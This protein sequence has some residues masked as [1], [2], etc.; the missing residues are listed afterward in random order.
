MNI[1]INA[2]R[3]KSGG[4]IR[5][6][7]GIITEIEPEILKENNIHIWSYKNLLNKINSKKNIIKHQFYFSKFNLLLQLFWEFCLL[8]I[9]LRKNKIDILINVDAGSVCYF[10][11]SICISRDMLP[12]EPEV[13]KKFGLIFKLRNKILKI[14]HIASLNNATYAIFLTNY[15]AEKIKP[16][17]KDNLKYK[18]I[19]HGVD[20]NFFLKN[21]IT[22]PKF[23]SSEII[24]TYI[25][26]CLPYKNHINVIEAIY[27]LRKKYNLNL[28]F[29]IIGEITNYSKKDIIS[30]I[31]KFSGEGAF[32]KV[33]ENIKQKEIPIILKNSH[34]FIFASSCENMPN[35]LL[36][37]MA[38][39]LPIACSNVGSMPEI[40]KD[41]GIYFNPQSILSIEKALKKLII[42]EDLRISYKNL[43]RKLAYNY[44]WK[45]SSK[46]TFKT[47]IKAFY[48]YKRN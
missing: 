44:S 7:K 20:N 46:N 33:K 40:L 28:K 19:P 41:G 45:R 17:L 8:P 32:V 26:P 24:I 27:N 38:S 1:A 14:T 21:T 42:D 18:I 39:G 4:G 2:S 13:T 35:T 11:P 43:S 25:S 30:T 48:K 15:A 9:E 10:K 6:I 3:A 12:F 47:A 29:E 5:H 16:F 37:G 36:E 23:N 31:K 22:Y 34:I